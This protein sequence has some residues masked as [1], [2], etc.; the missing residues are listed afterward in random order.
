M[1]ALSDMSE[2]HFAYVCR[3]LHAHELEGS[4]GEA[5][6]QQDHLQQQPQPQQEG[7]S[8]R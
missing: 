4:C 5:A 7:D 2:V 8:S 6:G 1:D 3:K